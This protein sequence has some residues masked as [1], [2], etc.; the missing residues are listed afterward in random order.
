M[1]QALAPL[2]GDIRKRIVSDSR[3]VPAASTHKRQKE[4]QPQVF[5]CEACGEHNAHLISLTFDG[6]YCG[7]CVEEDPELDGWKWESIW[8]GSLRKRRWH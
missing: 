3:L 4:W 2:P 5:E 8:E 1:I 7:K 6:Y